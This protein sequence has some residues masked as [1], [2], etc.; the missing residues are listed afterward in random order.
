[1]RKQLTE[2]QK[3]AEREAARRYYVK[4][5]ERILARQ[6]EFKKMNKEVVAERQAKY[7]KKNSKKI[8]EY[9]SAWG[10]ANKER[11]KAKNAEWAKANPHIVRERNARRR[12]LISIATPAWASWFVMSEIRDL[13]K[14]RTAATGIQH[15][16][17]HIVPLKSELVC[18]LH[19]ESNL[20]V[21]TW[22]KNREKHNLCWPDMPE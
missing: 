13:A 16:V 1:M 22:A 5:S 9:H 18:G 17:D 6:A 19:C 15:C 7:R 3:A 12:A 20:Q 21:I 11:L 14:R 2:Q 8:A 4:N 10:V